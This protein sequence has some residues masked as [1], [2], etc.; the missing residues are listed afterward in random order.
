MSMWDFSPGPGIEPLWQMLN[1]Q[2]RPISGL[3]P[4]AISGTPSQGGAGAV[5]LAPGTEGRCAHA[6]GLGCS[7]WPVN[8]H[9]ERPSG[10]PCGAGGAR[11]LPVSDSRALSVPTC[12]R[13]SLKLCFNPAFPRVATVLKKLAHSTRADREGNEAWLLE[14]MMKPG[15][16]SC[17]RWRGVS[18]THS[19]RRC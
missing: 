1:H 15:S 14:R 18:L 12:P 19:A 10:A 4:A 11:T 2:G 9:R 13:S 6:R 16:E 3:F 5:R 7:S 8:V 17:R